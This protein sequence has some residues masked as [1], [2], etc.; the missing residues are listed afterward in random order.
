MIP[1]RSLVSQKI[2]SKSRQGMDSDPNSDQL[3]EEN[4]RLRR[5][6]A[7]AKQGAVNHGFVQVSR[8]TLITW[9]NLDFAPLR[10]V[11]CLPAWSKP[12]TV[13]IPWH[14]LWSGRPY[15]TRPSLGVHVNT[16][17]KLKAASDELFDLVLKKKIK[18]LLAW[19]SRVRR[20]PLWRRV[21]PR[22]QQS[23]RWIKRKKTRQA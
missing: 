6:L 8:N 7:K 3:A 9:M 21:K 20:R 10:P 17:D 2:N 11:S 12:W 4:S 13:S 5:E 14:P 15:V 1:V 16:P 18:A 19:K 23:W 22:V